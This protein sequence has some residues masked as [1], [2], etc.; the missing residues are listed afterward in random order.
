MLQTKK[1][2]QNSKIH[3]WLLLISL[4]TKLQLIVDP[5]SVGVLPPKTCPHGGLPHLLLSSII[6]VLHLQPSV[7]VWSQRSSRSCPEDG[8]LDVPSTHLIPGQTLKVHITVQRGL[9]WD[10][11]LYKSF[12]KV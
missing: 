7:L 8:T 11:Q 3:F 5:S 1:N 10:Q 12:I 2:R 9:F 6:K 4:L